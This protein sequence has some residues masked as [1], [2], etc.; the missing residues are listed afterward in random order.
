MRTGARGVALIKRFEGLRLGAYRDVAGV[1]TIGYGHT[2]EDV[3]PGDLITRERA[4]ELLRV[5]LMRFESGVRNRVS[6]PLNQNE[7]DALV[8]LAFNIGLDAFS[9]STVRRRLNAHNRTGAA[10]AFLMW[11]LAD[12]DRNGKTE[13]HEVSPGLKR[14]REAERALFLEPTP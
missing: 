2:G 1:W 12:L 9:R 14:R 6:V 5:D 3:R 8:S 11:K 13:A 10:D 7:F 4:E